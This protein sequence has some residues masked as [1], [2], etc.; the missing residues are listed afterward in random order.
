MK[1]GFSF[2][3]I[4]VAIVI[5]IGSTHAIP[6]AA[7]QSPEP[8]PSSSEQKRQIGEE[9]PP[10]HGKAGG[11][12]MVP[13]DLFAMP[14]YDAIVSP[15]AKMVAVVVHRTAP[16]AASGDLWGLNHRCELWVIGLNG[17]ARKLLTPKEP[18]KLSQWNPVWSPDG[19]Q[20]AF[21]STEGDDN[22]FLEVWDRV[23]GQVRRLSTSGIDLDSVITGGSGAGS[24][25]GNKLVWLDDRRLMTI[26]LPKGM[27]SHGFDDD[28]KSIGIAS[29]GVKSAAAGI[30]PTSIVASSPPDRIKELPPPVARLVIFDPVKGALR[31][32]GEL[33]ASQARDSERDI[34]LSPDGKWAAINL[35]EPAHDA[36]SLQN[37]IDLD[38]VYSGQI[39]VVRLAGQ[40]SGIRWLE[41][42]RSGYTFLLSWRADNSEFVLSGHSAGNKRQICVAAVNAGSGEWQPIAELKNEQLSNDGKL[43][44]VVGLGILPNNQIALRI[45]NQRQSGDRRHTWWAVAGDRATPLASD[46]PRLAGKN[47]P[48]EKASI[49]VETND[50]GR[51]FTKDPAGHEET[52]FP[53]VAQLAQIE[54]PRYL[55]FHYSALDGSKQYAELI[56]PYGYVP[57]TKYPTV[58]WV[59]AGDVNT[60]PNDRV[61]RDVDSF[62]NLMLLTGHGYAVLIPSIPLSLAGLPGDPMLH[63]NDGVDPAVNEA[64]AMGIADPDRLALFG[65]SYGGYSVSGLITQSRRYRAG[66]AAMGFSDLV[67]LYG[68]FDARYRYTHPNEAAFD[69]LYLESAQGRMGVPL[70]ADPER[71]VRNSPIF[72]ADRITTP[73][74]LIDGELDLFETQNQEMFTALNRQGKRAEYICYLGENHYIKS[75]ANILD[76]WQRAFSWLDTYVKNPTAGNEPK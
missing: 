1:C 19:Q 30:E 47:S 32:V 14:G 60:G 10:I 37:P 34:V 41:G 73:L 7:I 55:E 28:S 49:T 64:V 61:K 75:P 23:T 16:G 65:H 57:G 21:L 69:P 35:L 17:G 29:E 8:A 13:K 63:L 58:V 66:I 70:W 46:D 9:I 40:A 44:R 2:R 62:L 3:F 38:S 52:L 24:Y 33:P 67:A 31:E 6:L 50:R 68:G 4:L 20:L 25:D 22:A 11:R 56:L 15:D 18:V 45:S 39:G 26:V 72:A 59:Y 42:I 54:E 27:H 5:F 76:F 51:L 74:L 53:E 12:P 43:I 71:Y 36:L 48:E